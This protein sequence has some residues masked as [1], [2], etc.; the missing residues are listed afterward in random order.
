MEATAT[1]NVKTIAVIGAGNVSTH[2]ALGL[3]NAH[4][5]I[6]QIYSHTLKSASQLAARIGCPAIADVNELS[7]ADAYLVAIKDDAIAPLLDSVPKILRNRLWM[8]TS[9]SVGLSVFDRFN[10]RHGVIYPLQT[11]SKEV[12]LPLGKVPFFIEG[13]SPAETAEIH[14][15]ASLISPLVYEANSETR[16]R[17]H[18]AAIF[19]CNFTNYMFT[20]ADELLQKLHLPFTT[21]TPL[22]EETLRKASEIPPYEAQTGPAARGDK[23]VLAKHIGL[24]DGEK[25]LI[26]KTISELIL[27]KYQTK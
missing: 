14:S 11:F 7:D 25:Q 20:I 18:I 1:M 26:Y 13:A 10:R 9:G 12:E 24:L 3:A 8:H 23:G 6:A 22:I 19:A 16:T 15:I 21:L 5:K 4:V 27:Q 17:V 2:L